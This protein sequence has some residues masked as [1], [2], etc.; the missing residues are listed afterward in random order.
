MLQLTLQMFAWTKRP[1]YL[2]RDHLAPTAMVIGLVLLTGS[3]HLQPILGQDAGLEPLTPIQQVA[4]ERDATPPLASRIPGWQARTESAFTAPLCNFHVSTDSWFDQIQSSSN[5]VC[6]HWQ[7]ALVENVLTKDQL[8]LLVNHSHSDSENKRTNRDSI[9]LVSF[10]QEQESNS[11]A[12]ESWKLNR[13]TSLSR[14][15]R[16]RC[17]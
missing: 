11:N 1:L 6:G 8:K 13:P 9:Q 14:M 4:P 3:F 12:G 16:F 15:T 7:P 10:H 17:N 2:S 5:L